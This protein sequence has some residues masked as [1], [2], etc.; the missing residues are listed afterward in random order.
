MPL[1]RAAQHA[2]RS[3]GLKRNAIVSDGDHWDFADVLEART[4]HPADGPHLRRFKK[5]AMAAVIVV[6]KIYGGLVPGIDRE[7]RRNASDL[8][9]PDDVWLLLVIQEKRGRSE[10]FAKLKYKR[11]EQRGASR[12]SRNLFVAD[13]LAHGR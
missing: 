11:V 4:A 1:C 13:V 6:C 7:M 3:D 2:R 10:E 8:D 9:V 12:I 5:V